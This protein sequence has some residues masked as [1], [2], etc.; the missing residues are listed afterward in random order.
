MY[1]IS[2]NRGDDSAGVVNGFELKNTAKP[3]RRGIDIMG[4]L[5]VKE[6]PCPHKDCPNNAKCCL[7]VINHRTHGL[8]FCLIKKT[9]EKGEV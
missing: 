1:K 5:N 4:C 6:C 9:G 8:P 2:S 3:K 7:C